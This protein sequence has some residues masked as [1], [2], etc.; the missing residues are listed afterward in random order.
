LQIE[1]KKCFKKKYINFDIKMECSEGEA[2]TA[3]DSEYVAHAVAV[4]SV[5]QLSVRCIKIGNI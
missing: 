5:E 2:Q 1:I 4:H 3:L